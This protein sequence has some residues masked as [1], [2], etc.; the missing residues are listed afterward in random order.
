MNR[1]PHGSTVYLVNAPE[2]LAPYCLFAKGSGAGDALKSYF[3]DNSIST[4][5]RLKEKTIN[6]ENKNSIYLNYY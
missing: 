5:I 2:W 3:N 1:P 4:K 6:S